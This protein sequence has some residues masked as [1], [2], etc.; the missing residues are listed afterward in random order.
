MI[1][2]VMPLKPIDR[3]QV[4]KLAAMFCTDEEIAFT[5]RLKACLP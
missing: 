4:H 3:N 1:R 5:H 2:M